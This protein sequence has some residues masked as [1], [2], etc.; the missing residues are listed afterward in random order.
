MRVRDGGETGHAIR[1]LG[2]SH[3]NRKLFM[4]ECGR[5]LPSAVVPGSTLDEWAWRLGISRTA[6]FSDE[7]S[8]SDNNEAALALFPLVF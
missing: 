3:L 5:R 8:D 4:F 2:L 7:E 1:N 6:E